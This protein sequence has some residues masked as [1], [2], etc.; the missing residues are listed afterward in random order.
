MIEE[1]KNSPCLGLGDVAVSFQK[2]VHAVDGPN[3]T[4][5]QHRT[6]D[7]KSKWTALPVEAP[8]SQIELYCGTLSPRLPRKLPISVWGRQ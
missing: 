8:V 4:K 7:T 1:E 3:T 6:R 5:V 2:L